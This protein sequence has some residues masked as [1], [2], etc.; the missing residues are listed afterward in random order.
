MED[1]NNALRKSVNCEM[2]AADQ[3]QNLTRFSKAAAIIKIISEKEKTP[4]ELTYAEKKLEK[5]F[6]SI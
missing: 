5:E 4:R 6:K 2:L 1:A 3:E